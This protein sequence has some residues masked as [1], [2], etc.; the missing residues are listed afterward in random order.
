MANL[1]HMDKLEAVNEILFSIGESPVQAL[2]SG[3]GDAAI[4][5]SILNRSNR[6]IQLKGWHVNTLR[7]WS[8]SKAAD[9]RFELPV[10][11]LA[12]DTVN[13]SGSRQNT[14]PTPSG[15]I[16]AGMRR[17]ADDTNWLMFD[18]DNNTEIWTSETTLTVDIVKLIDFDHL[19]PALQIY[20]WTH[21]ANRFQQG[22]MGSR[23]LN[24][25]TRGDVL[26]AE[27]QAVQEDSANEDINLIRQNG[28]INAIAWRNS[29]LY[30]R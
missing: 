22:I 28:F 15:F 11:T 19:T 20:V 25:F 5:E 4:A 1:G 16:N 2:E 30:G 24:E 7:N 21:A 29:P 13:P 17:A 26:E 12:V 27:T 18:N 3:L 14:T 10:D 23:V 8:L 6:S 9:N